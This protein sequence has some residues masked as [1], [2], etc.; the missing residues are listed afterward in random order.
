MNHKKMGYTNINKK[1]E[2]DIGSRR[3][4]R[5][6]KLPRSKIGTRKEAIAMR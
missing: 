1:E 6:L 4:D 2:R 3:R 5:L